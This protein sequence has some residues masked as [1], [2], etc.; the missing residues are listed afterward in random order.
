M[1]HD[2]AWVLA[3]RALLNQLFQIPHWMNVEL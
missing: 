2:L 1:D 3:H